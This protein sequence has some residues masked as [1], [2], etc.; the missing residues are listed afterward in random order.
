MPEEHLR[1]TPAPQ[2][3]SSSCC[4]GVRVV[5]RFTSGS[6]WGVGVQFPHA[7]FIMQIPVKVELG[8]ALPAAAE[9]LCLE[10]G[11]AQVEQGRPGGGV[12]AAE[13]GA[14]THNPNTFPPGLGPPGLRACGCI[15]TTTPH[16]ESLP[17]A[18]HS[19]GGSGESSCAQAGSGGVDF[20]QPPT[21][22][23]PFQLNKALGCDEAH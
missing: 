21:I 19:W 20:W 5:C 13:P 3:L 14:V 2:Y 7:G 12:S 10:D 18:P 11:A 1:G 9:T 17:T 23:L 6:E 15:C 16:P 8:A 4:G 22:S